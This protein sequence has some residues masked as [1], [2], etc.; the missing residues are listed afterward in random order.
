MSHKK[1]KKKDKKR[2]SKKRKRNM[3]VF[4]FSMKNFKK[5]YTYDSSMS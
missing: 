3:K 1:N 5:T 4:L 2:H